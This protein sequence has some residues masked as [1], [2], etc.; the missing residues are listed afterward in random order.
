M[1]VRQEHAVLKEPRICRRSSFTMS[2]EQHG[3][4]CKLLSAEK[5]SDREMKVTFSRAH[6]GLGCVVP[7]PSPQDLQCV[8][9]HRKRVSCLKWG[10]LVRSLFCSHIVI[11]EATHPEIY[12]QDKR[13]QNF[14]R[15][16]LIWQTHFTRF[17]TYWSNEGSMLLNKKRWKNDT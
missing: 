12:I 2:T 5:K 16:D 14:G 3:H 13:N 17:Q 11:I 15:K 9:Q 1:S 8:G 10:L 7:V 6:T 4:L